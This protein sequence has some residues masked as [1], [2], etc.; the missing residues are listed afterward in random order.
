LLGALGVLAVP[1]A[2]LVPQKNFIDKEDEKEYEEV[3]LSPL[4]SSSTLIR[5]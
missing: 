2:S 1:L 4:F 3:S 5:S